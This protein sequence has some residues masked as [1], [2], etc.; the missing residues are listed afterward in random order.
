MV[1]G[2]AP[3]ETHVHV[4]EKDELRDVIVTVGR[5]AYTRAG[6]SLRLVDPATRGACRGAPP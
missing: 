6:R 2:K 1:V 4:R 3:G 5:G